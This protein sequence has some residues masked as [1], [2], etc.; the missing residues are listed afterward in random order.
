V[1][2]ASGSW[3]GPYEIV[4]L[5]GAGG[6]GVV[7]EA[8]D[9]RLQRTVAI[10]LLGPDLTRDQTAK[11]R[12]LREARAA[13]ALDHPNICTIHDVE[14]TDEGHLYLV[15]ARYDGETLESRIDRGPL[16]LPD[17]LDVAEQI[18]RGLAEAHGAGIVHRDIKPANLLVTRTGAVKILDF[19]LAKLAGTE[20][21]TQTGTALGTVAYMSPEQA[22]GLP[23]DH[24]AD[25]WSLGVVLYEMLTGTRPFRGDNLLAISRAI[26]EHEPAALTGP[27][28][29]AQ[30]VVT[31]ALRK[32]P[33]ERYASA[34]ELLAGLEAIRH[35]SAIPVEPS[36]G[37]PEILSIAVL[38][39]TNM[40]PDPE[41]AYFSDGLSEEIINALSR[42]SGL[43]VIARSSAF[44]FRGEQDLRRVGAALGVG[45][46]LEGSVRK[47]GNR[48]RIIA[49]L[50]D[51]GSDSHLW[52]ERFDRELT[53]VF[54]IQEEIASAIVKE[55]DV[56]LTG[57]ARDRGAA[58]PRT[59]SVPAYEA[60]LEGRHH[61]N[62]F[63]PA[64]A[65]KAM[66]CFERAL[67]LDPDYPDVLVAMALHYSV[68]GWLF[69]EP[70]HAVGRMNALAAQALARDPE[71]GDAYGALAFGTLWS[72]WDWNG[73]DRLFRRAI[74][75]A[76]ASA[77]NLALYGV[78][79]CL[80]QG[81][82]DKAA[83]YVERGRRLDPFAGRARAL[84]ARILLCRR[85]FAEAEAS[86]RRSLELDPGHPLVQW[87]LGYALAGQGKLEEALS[88]VMGAMRA[89]GPM[90]IFLPLLGLVY[91]R[92]G[93]RDEATQILEGRIELGEAPFVPPT[94]GIAV[95]SALSDLDAAF[96]WAHKSIDQ[97]DPMMM[98]L[99]VHPLF[100]ALRTD[101]RYPALLRR[102]HL[103]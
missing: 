3:L 45:A 14:E 77:N 35:S 29:A 81:A 67:S 40:S 55:L 51:V 84:E 31:R 69:G 20:A 19:G 37:H 33:S 18:A 65:E 39:F 26:A 8:R 12:F 60:L 66:A 54:A 2:L 23:V 44:R 101:P 41:N 78:L 42:L 46:V 47:A 73:A 50:V 79:C 25:I 91:G 30:P 82:V 11:E 5:L 53:D 99:K 93:L 57:P 56:S 32:A 4:A 49:Q 27:A 90:K 34:G 88:V 95:Y 94:A 58:P 83:A 1:T 16:P 71:H 89:H 86:A 92:A 68:V 28:S 17:A 70:R 74:G 72:E 6:M 97:I 15:M 75:L 59:G 52:S 38:P 80:G 62:T 76:P 61:W 22:R 64:G 87:E 96:E 63:T 24:L 9:S 43:R 36:S 98:Y 100:D 102:V 13:S 10:K 21:V 48:L 7:Y 85:R 103:A